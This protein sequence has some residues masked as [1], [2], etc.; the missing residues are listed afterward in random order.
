MSDVVIYRAKDGHA[1][2]EVQ[3]DQETVW[4]NLNQM[5]KLFDRD[6]SVISRHLSAIFKTNELSREATVAKNA[7]VQ[8]EGGREVT[9]LIESFNLDEIANSGGTVELASGSWGKT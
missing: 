3:L 6:K 7:T 1:K 8:I 5:V 9:R 2:L 4:L